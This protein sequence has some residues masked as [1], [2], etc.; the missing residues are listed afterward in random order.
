MIAGKG[1]DPVLVVGG[2]L[3][4][5]LLAHDRSSDD[6]AEEVDD[7]LRPRQTAQVA[8]DDNAVEAVINEDEKITE[9]LDEEFHGRPPQTHQT[10]TGQAH[11]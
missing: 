5:Q 11:G 6:V 1:L 9:Q 8:V 7:L 2:P 4:Q 10:W 3:A